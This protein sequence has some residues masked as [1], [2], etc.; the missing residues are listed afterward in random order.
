MEGTQLLGNHM[1]ASSSISDVITRAQSGDLDALGELFDLHH[2]AVFQYLRSRVN[3]H[4]LAE[5]LTGEVFKRMLTNLYQ[6]RTRTQPFRAW[7]FRIAHNLMVDHFRREGKHL[8][9]PLVEQEFP[10]DDEGNPVL[11]VE[12]N[13][14]VEQVFQALAVLEPLQ[15]DVL[16][17][18]FLSGLSLQEVAFILN[19]T[20]D[21]IKAHQRRG[22]AA[23]R[24][25]LAQD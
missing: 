8:H 12:M 19:R 5:D 18:R 22:L 7:L 11:K 25:A 6:Y 23:L 15:R 3:D 17:L 16:A 1:M 10:D 21:S 9:P 4:H 20:E 2:Q 13:Q 14:A 24:I